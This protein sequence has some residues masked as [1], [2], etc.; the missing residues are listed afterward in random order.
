MSV[1]TI[2][3]RC[4]IVIQPPL[5]ITRLNKTQSCCYEKK[6]TH[7]LFSPLGPHGIFG[8]AKK[9]N[10]NIHHKYILRTYKGPKHISAAF[11]IKKEDILYGKLLI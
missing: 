11:N 6:N 5:V 10:Q 2:Q 4:L 8:S 9:R 3:F 1:F 7:T